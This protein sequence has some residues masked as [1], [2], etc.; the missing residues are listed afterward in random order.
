MRVIELLET[1]LMREKA[2][3]T[4]TKTANKE[5]EKS[6]LLEQMKDTAYDYLKEVLIAEVEE[7]ESLLIDHH[8]PAMAKFKNNLTGKNRT[9]AENLTDWVKAKLTRDIDTVK[10]DKT[11]YW[12]PKAGHVHGHEL[13]DYPDAYGLLIAMIQREG[14]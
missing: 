6:R 10:I 13:V 9:E 2:M 8:G 3:K 4:A 5:H 11:Y 1:N 12:L 7:I 14:A